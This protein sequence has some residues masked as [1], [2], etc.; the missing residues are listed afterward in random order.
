MNTLT[1]VGLA[2]IAWQL[3]KPTV[4]IGKMGKYKFIPVYSEL[5][6]G[7]KNGKTNIAFAKGKPGVYIIK[8]NN[9]IVYVGYS[10]TDVYRTALRH[11]QQWSDS[12]YPNRITYVDKLRSKKYTIRIVLTS[13]SRAIKLETGL[14]RKHKPRDNFEKLNS[15]L[16]E[17]GETQIQKVVD[18]Y[19]YIDTEEAPF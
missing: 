4:E 3:F 11:F 2:F 17:K 16:E 1:K 8:E 13:A 5:P 14:I 15:L 10:G 6:E 12:A 7:S 18:E 19:T 9:K